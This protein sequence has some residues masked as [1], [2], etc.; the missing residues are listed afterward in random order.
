MPEGPG[1]QA[2]LLTLIG[3]VWAGGICLVYFVRLIARFLGVQL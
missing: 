3:V 2:R 1:E